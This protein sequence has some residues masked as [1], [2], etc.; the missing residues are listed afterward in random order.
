MFF[1]VGRAMEALRD[2]RVD[3]VAGPAHATLS[4][5]PLA[6]AK[7]LAALSR[8]TF[9]VLVLRSDLGVQPG[10]VAAVKG[11]R[12]GAA[13]GPGRRP[14]PVAGRGGHRPSAGRRGA[15][16]GTGSG[17][18]GCPSA[19]MPPKPGGGINRW[20]LGQC[21]GSRSGGAEWDRQRGA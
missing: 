13:P 14:A 17:E 8:H 5:F 1:P 10:D 15:S 20:V 2:R 6:G 3:F 19:S 9:W 21:D 12:I 16:S 7:L 11:L 18:P 4:A